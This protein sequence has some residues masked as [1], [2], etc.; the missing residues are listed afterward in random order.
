[1]ALEET[2]MPYKTLRERTMKIVYVGTD[3][4]RR[5]KY[6][7]GKGDVLLLLYDKWDAYNCKTS[8]PTACKI[9]DSIVDLG[10]IRILVEDE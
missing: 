4:K 1:M 5:K 2:S 10:A 6:L 9:D 3:T 7:D 8:F